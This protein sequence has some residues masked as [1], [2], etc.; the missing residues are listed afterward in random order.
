MI[1]SA[2]RSQLSL[3]FSND[4]ILRSGMHECFSHRGIASTGCAAHYVWTMDPPLQLHMVL[5]LVNVIGDLRRPSF[6]VSR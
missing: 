4:G 5:Q 6:V 3:E 2:L 1:F